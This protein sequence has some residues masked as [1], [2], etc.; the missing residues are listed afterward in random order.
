MRR[1][2]DLTVPGT[3][4]TTD[5]TTGDTTDDTLVRRAD[6]DAVD[7]PDTADDPWWREPPL[8]GRGL[9]TIVAAYVSM[10]AVLTTVGLL[11]VWLWEG[12]AL[13]R[14]D[15]DVNEWLADRRT[16]TWTALS[17]DASRLSDTMTM[18]VACALLLV[19]FLWA[20]RRWHD[21]ALVVG[22]LVLEVT[23]FVTV[24]FLVGRERPPV[25]QLDGAPTDS[26]PSGHIAA[27][28][29][30]YG[31]LAVVVRWHTSRAWVAR[32]AIVGAVVA[33]TLVTASRLYR[34]MHYPTDAVAGA[35][36]GLGAIGAVYVALQRGSRRPLPVERE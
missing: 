34:G 7:R 21:W 1:S 26:F 20:F 32:L 19:P 10:T 4:D 5:G 8:D 3:D 2:V 27:A 11:V 31:A 25:S 6:R 36:L 9:L 17:D 22:A 16:P 24:T 23:T 18:V 35:L 15:A 12:S 14:L 30:F 28:V 33:A 13:G 29:A